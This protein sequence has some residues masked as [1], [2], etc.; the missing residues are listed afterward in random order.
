MSEEVKED[1]LK[2]GKGRRVSPLIGREVTFSVITLGKM[3]KAGVDKRSNGGE[4]IKAFDF[5]S[6]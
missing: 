2:K 1:K 4:K 6:L 3:E 5:N